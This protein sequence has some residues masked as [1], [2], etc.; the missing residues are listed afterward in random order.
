M[1]EYLMIAEV[2]KPQGIKGEVKLKPYTADVTSFAEWST[3]FREEKGSYLPLNSKVTRIQ[4]DF[5]YTILGNASS[6]D[7]AEKFRG[8]K[9]YIDR[10]HV[11][12]TDP[13]E[14]LIADLEGCRAVDENGRELGV[15]TEVLQYGS[16]DTYV[17]KT[18][19]GIMMA[20]AL[21]SVFPDVDVEAGV[22]TVCSEKLQEVAV[23]ED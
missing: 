5:V 11:H 3:L 7:E 20:P 2:L 17:F 23:F 12:S 15:L 16:V 19:K 22:I 14:V 6:M 8:M 21:L 10:A 18:E 9:L 13:N 4:S 1:K